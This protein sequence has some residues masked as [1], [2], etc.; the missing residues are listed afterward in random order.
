MQYPLI[1]A[2]SALPLLASCGGSSPGGGIG[3]TCGDGLESNGSGSV[4]GDGAQ[5]TISDAGVY[6]Q[7]E[8]GELFPYS[9]LMGLLG[10]DPCDNTLTFSQP[11]GVT[12]TQLTVT[13]QLLDAPA[14]GSYD[15]SSAKVCGGVAVSYF[16]PNNGAE[17][18]MDGAGNCLQGGSGTP[19]GSYTL[20][21]TTVAPYDAGDG[22]TYWKVH[23][24]LKGSMV[25]AIGTLA[26][27]GISFDM[28]F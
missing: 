10:L 23:G 24:S 25:P 13:L 17:W 2:F 7:D 19:N 27:A 22:N 6:F 15:N 5:G 3:T 21:L 9:F 20:D 18:L 16:V 28:S 8:T 4:T 26:D 11:S 14:V 12:G 1:A